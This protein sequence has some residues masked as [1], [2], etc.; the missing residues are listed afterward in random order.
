MGAGGKNIRQAARTFIMKSETGLCLVTTTGGELTRCR[1]R[2]ATSTISASLVSSLSV[3]VCELA[4]AVD[5]LAAE[6]L[7]WGGC[8]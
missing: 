3:E 6:R 8:L 2:E 4:T 5:S 7:C 1:A